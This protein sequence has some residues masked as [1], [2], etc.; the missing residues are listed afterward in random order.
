L[1]IFM[2]TIEHLINDMLLGKMSNMF[3]SL[4]EAGTLREPKTKRNP[5]NKN[6][7]AFIALSKKAKLETEANAIEDQHAKTRDALR[8]NVESRKKRSAARLDKRISRRASLRPPNEQQKKNNVK[9]ATKIVPKSV[10]PPPP[11]SLDELDLGLETKNISESVASPS[12]AS[13]PPPSMSDTKEDLDVLAFVD[14]LDFGGKKKRRC[15]SSS[16]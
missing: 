7:T 3:G 9:S 5:K 10:T 13:P 11:S 1:E 6:R 15:G 12:P 14:G 2:G 8:Q 4:P 16:H